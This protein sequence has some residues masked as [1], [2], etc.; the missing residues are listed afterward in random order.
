MWHKN[1]AYDSIEQVWYEYL[2]GHAL[3]FLPNRQDQDFAVIADDLDM[4]ILT[5]GDDSA[6]RRIAELKLA[7]AVLERQK[8]IL[9]VCHG[10]FLLA[11]VLGSRI[12]EKAGHQATEHTIDYAGQSYMVN[13]YHNLCI[14]DLHSTARSLARDQDGDCEAWIDGSTAGVVWHPER[15]AD[16]WLPDEI[17]QLTG[18]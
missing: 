12:D 6:T 16:P 4:L 13:S 2:D 8:P 17:K 3:I 9:G 7:S 14:R 11:E 10:C 5:G 1:R 18:L 15:M